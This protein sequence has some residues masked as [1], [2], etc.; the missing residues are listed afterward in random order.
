MSA[1]PTPNGESLALQQAMG[2]GAPAPSDVVFE[3][4]VNPDAEIAKDAAGA[5]AP[6][7]NFL[8]E[9]LRTQGYRTSAMRAIVIQPG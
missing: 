3:A 5:T 8:S 6:P 4:T 7:G 2:L 9:S 1:Q